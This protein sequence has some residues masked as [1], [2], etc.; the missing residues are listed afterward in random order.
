[1]SAVAGAIAGGELGPRLWLYATYSC[2]LSCDY[3][4]TDSSPRAP[5]MALDPDRMVALATEAAALGF[6]GL[7]VTGGEPFTVPSMVDTL[8]R[9]AEV[10]PVLVL[11][12][13]TLFTDRLLDRMRRL[14]GVSVQ[15][16]LDS[17]DG[18]VNDAERGVGNF[19]KVV[20]AIP[21]LVAVGVPVRVATTGGERDAEA[22]ERLCALHR[23]LGVVDDDHVVRPIVRR[24]RAIGGASVPISAEVLPPELT[25]T[26][27]GA[28]WSPFA[29]TVDGGGRDTDMLISRR[30]SPLSLPAA[31]I[32]ALIRG[33]PPGSEAT[34]DI[35]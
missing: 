16:S 5:A 25:I 21:K 4:L 34:L 35:L 29:P 17:A 14:A 13:G 2:N 12:N 26:A 3:C 18:S 15:V 1:M 6:T 22:R 30:T 33:R 11:T 10:L 7:G 19:E 32:V 27:D 31:D 9:L 28:Y 8:A 24:G 20:A 23:R